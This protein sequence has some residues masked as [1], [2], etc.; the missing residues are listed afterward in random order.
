MAEEPDHG[1]NRNRHSE[2]PGQRVLPHR[3]LL[4][5]GARARAD[6]T[7]DPGVASAVLLEQG[8]Y[9][10]A[11][12]IKRREEAFAASTEFRAG[13]IAQSACVK[14]YEGDREG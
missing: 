3:N 2:Q 8:P 5:D 12:V 6:P 1:Q 11:G 14:E 13:Q 9:P 4:I 7:V 10:V